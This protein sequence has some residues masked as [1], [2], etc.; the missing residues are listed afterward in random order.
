M[1]SASSARDDVYSFLIAR[2][3]AA[4]AAL[5]LGIDEMSAEA[6]ETLAGVLVA[7][8]E[9]LGAALASG[10]ESSGRSSA[11]CNAMD[12]LRAVEI[13]TSPA[14]ERLHIGG[15]SD[16][17]QAAAVA[18]A[19]ESATVL[20]STVAGDPA[21]DRSWQGLAAFCFG[22]DW[23]TTDA[24]QALE[25]EAEA[26]MA[27]AQQAA[28]G[29]GGGKVGPASSSKKEWGWKAP[30]PDEVPRF[31]LSQQEWHPAIAAAGE[32]LHTRVAEQKTDIADDDL[33]DAALVSD[34]G[35]LK[36]KLDEEQEERPTR[37]VRIDVETSA[38]AD[39]KATE[40]KPG[41]EYVPRFYPPFPK[42]SD[43]IAKTVED[44][45]EEAE[46]QASEAVV[47]R[48]DPALK[49]R[50]A[51]VELSGDYWGSG[52]EQQ[53]TSIPAVPAGRSSDAEVSAS[54][55]PLG[56]ASGSRVSRILE[57]S[58]DAAGGT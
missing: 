20:A 19:A 6:L 55:V 5:H 45:E 54:I 27:D 38:A 23:A 31:P 8:L 12:A 46:S 24:E 56:R 30:Y 9:R 32:T 18:A 50:T 3:A 28:A 11:H 51:L 40:A 1:P 44:V 22:P 36:R 41:I 25:A 26:T 48:D 57:G 37:K 33:P 52:W 29:G 34:W 47:S 16:V 2:R 15:A 10:V 7:Y 35:S 21:Q 17:E 43:S 13:C 58:M 42:P 4:R 14:V 53:E 39:H 49:V